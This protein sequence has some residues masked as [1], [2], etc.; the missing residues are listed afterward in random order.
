MPSLGS[1]W[2]RWFF[3]LFF[4][5]FV[6][7]EKLCSAR[8]A[9][10]SASLRAM[11]LG[12]LFLHPSVR[13]SLL[14]KS[15]SSTSEERSESRVMYFCPLVCLTARSV[16]RGKFHR[17]ENL[18]KPKKNCSWLMRRPCADVIGLGWLRWKVT[19]LNHGRL[20]LSFKGLSLALKD[21]SVQPSAQ[22]KCCPGRRNGK[23]AQL[24]H[25]PWLYNVKKVRIFN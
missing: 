22:R 18:I 24:Q 1:V 4:F 25:Q 16:C 21:S 14:I 10:W 20:I 6:P 3:L 19:L 23:C 13:K 17:R 8:W 5:F 9:P 12:C 2:A 7:V 15:P 11:R